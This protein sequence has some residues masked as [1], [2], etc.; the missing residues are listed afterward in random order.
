MYLKITP[1]LI[2]KEFITKMDE[3]IDRILSRLETWIRYIA[4]GFVFLGIAWLLEPEEARKIFCKFKEFYWLT[5]VFVSLIGVAIYAVHQNTVVRFLF[6]FIVSILKIPRQTKC[7]EDLR[8]KP[9]FKVMQRIEEERWLRR[10]SG[11]SGVKMIQRTIDSWASLMNFL[12]CSSY[13]LVVLPLFIGKN[14]CWK[15]ELL[16]SSVILFI[17]ALL[18]DFRI[19]LREVWMIKKYPQT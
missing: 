4:P 19:T 11:N 17:V 16:L 7:P 1:N 9:T 10:A 8:E 18:S 2:K 12:Y 15:E 6:W 14:S 3:A 13:S 5:S